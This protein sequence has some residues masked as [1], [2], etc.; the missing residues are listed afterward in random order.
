[1]TVYQLRELLDRFIA[2]QPEWADWEVL[3][4]DRPLRI[5][6]DNCT[7]GCGQGPHL[8]LTSNDTGYPR[9][10]HKRH[11]TT[12]LLSDD[13]AEEGK[14]PPPEYGFVRRL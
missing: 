7:H 1:M 4:A 11:K 6:A 2:T 9:I 10:L 3:F 8:R 14:P 5:L 13:P 12:V